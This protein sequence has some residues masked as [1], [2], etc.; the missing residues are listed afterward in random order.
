M[1]MSAALFRTKGIVMTRANARELAVHLIYGRVFTGEEPETVVSTRLSKEYY[2]KLA[3]ET[4]AVTYFRVDVDGIVDIC[5][6]AE[7]KPALVKLAEQFKYS[8]PVTGDA[9][10]DIEDTL[11]AMLAELKTQ[12]ISGDTEAILGLVKNLSLTLNERN[13]LCKA[14][15]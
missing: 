6:N 15:K 12:V 13:R 5:D 4:K 11:Q 7:A 14:G 1:S 10:K 9:T 8:D 3:Q 2:E